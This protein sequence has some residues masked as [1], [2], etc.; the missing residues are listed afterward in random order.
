MKVT[1]FKKVRHLSL[2]VACRRFCRFIAFWAV[3]M[4]SSGQ[5]W[6]D[7]LSRKN[8]E[9][10]ELYQQKNYPKALDKYVEAQDGK[11]Y[12]SELS[13]NLANT[14]YQQKK[15]AEAIQGIREGSFRWRIKTKRKHL[16]Q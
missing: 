8:S 15:Y 6:R 9:G 7:P 10:N 16:L 14:L 12:Q 2:D 13:Y 1:K 11:H 4:L 3:L 5:I